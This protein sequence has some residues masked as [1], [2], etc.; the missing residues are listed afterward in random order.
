[1]RGLV[2]E[3]RCH[4]RAQKAKVANFTPRYGYLL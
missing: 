2:G 3:T 4:N 1:M